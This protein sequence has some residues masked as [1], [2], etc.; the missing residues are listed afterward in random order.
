MATIATLE[1]VRTLRFGPSTRARARSLRAGLFV[2]GIAGTAGL[3]LVGARQPGYDLLIRGGR[4]VDGTGNPW[5]AGDVGI[6]GDRIVAV[7]RLAGATAHTGD[8][9]ARPGR[10]ARLHRPAHPFGSAAA[11]RRQ[12]REQGAA[13]RDAR[14]ASARARRS[15]R[16]TGCP[17][18]KGTWTD[19]TGYWQRARGRRASR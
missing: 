8:R 1:M 12:R 4:I 19:F 2:L 17:T 5:F 11:E 15:L 7:G 10:R 6:R 16:A 13:G 18:P 14:R 9:R 3:A